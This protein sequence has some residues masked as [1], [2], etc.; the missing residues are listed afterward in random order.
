MIH[1][2]NI[3]HLQFDIRAA[4]NKRALKRRP[5]EHPRPLRPHV[6]RPTF[7]KV[8]QIPGKLM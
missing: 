5:P 4:E 2:D 7:K 8:P 3:P 6:G 1:I